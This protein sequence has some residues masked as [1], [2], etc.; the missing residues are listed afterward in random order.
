MAMA[1]KLKAKE[2]ARREM[3]EKAAFLQK[4]D[5]EAAKER[6]V[7]EKA[8]REEKE[9]LEYEKAHEEEARLE[10]LKVWKTKEYF[11]LNKFGRKKDPEGWP[12]YFGYHKGTHG[13]WMP[14]GPGE[15]Y[16]EGEKVF[17]G[18][19]VEGLEHGTGATKTWKGGFKAGMVDGVGVYEGR[20]ALVRHSMIV[21]YQDEL[22]DGKCLEFYDQ[23]MHVP[24]LD[25]PVRATIINHVKGWRYRIRYHDETRPL[26]RTLDL[27]TLTNRDKAPFRV[28][29]DLPTVYHLN[30]WDMDTD[31][32]S[33]Y[34][35]WKE[36]YGQEERPKLGAVGGRRCGNTSPHG[37]KVLTQAQRKVTK[38]QENI[39][40]PRA[41]GIGEALELENVE[42]QREQKRKQFAKLI[43][44]RRAADEEEKK[45]AVAEEEAKQFQEQLEAQREKAQKRAEAEAKE[46]EA[47]AKALEEMKAKIKAEEEAE[48]ADD[49]KR[50]F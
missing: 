34:K 30:R 44:E 14:H 45:K 31:S 23:T 26:V 22:K 13:A 20:E 36:A 29:H 40:E 48:A 2:K 43:E 18:H 16:Y 28:R 37:V 10:K 12:S 11:E 47:D 35:F 7:R 42:F 24:N 39:F 27:S 41:V 38:Y 1:A 19:Y 6:A 46:K 4:K 21:C 8:A 33:S 25:G 17:E 50:G 32:V 3:E 9:R 5:I 15:M 49:S